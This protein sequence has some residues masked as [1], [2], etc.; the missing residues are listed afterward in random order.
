LRNPP[1]KRV[2]YAAFSTL[3]S[4]WN[5]NDIY[6]HMN[7]AV[8]Y[9]LFDTAVNGQLL[10]HGILHLEASPTVFLVAET[11][12]RYHAELSFPHDIHA[13]LRVARLGSSSVTYEIGLFSGDAETAAAE[14][15]FVHVNVDRISRKP[16]P[17]SARARAT[18]ETWQI[19]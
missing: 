6:G 14:G 1:G 13:G 7:N 18:L 8:H 17:I 5:D 16:A 15:H 11:G 12:C 10:H 2:D 19:S 9:Q 3:T 4:R